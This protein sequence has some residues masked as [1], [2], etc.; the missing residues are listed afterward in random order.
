MIGCQG[1]RLHIV[2]TGAHHCDVALRWGVKIIQAKTK[3][4]KISDVEIALLT[5]LTLLGAHVSD[6]GHRV[7][8]PIVCVISLLLLARLKK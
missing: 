1:W 5:R 2:V 7:I 3:S 6:P 4:D 8:I